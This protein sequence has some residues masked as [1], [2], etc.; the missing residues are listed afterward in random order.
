MK[1]PW[2]EPYWIPLF[3]MAGTSNA[4]AD[5]ESSSTFRTFTQDDSSNGNSDD[6]FLSIQRATS[7]IC[8][9]YND[10]SALSRS[11]FFSCL[12]ECCNCY[13]LRYVRDMMLSI[14]KRKVKQL[15]GPLV[16]RKGGSNLKDSLLK[17][18]Y[19]LYSFREGSVQSLPKNM[20]KCD[21]KYVN[22]STETDACL[23][24]TIFASNLDLD[25]LED[26]LINRISDLR[27]EMLNTWNA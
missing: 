2:L 19:N 18:V 11:D 24:N 23:S 1:L 21:T 17:D 14:V 6:T 22:Q 13:K 8:K 15:V 7:T 25:T 5:L 26:E 10:F 4:E 16:E 12:S 9:I 27:H 3:E 20:I